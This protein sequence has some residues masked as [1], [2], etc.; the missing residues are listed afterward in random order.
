MLMQS[1]AIVSTP[2]ITKY[3]RRSSPIVD[4]APSFLYAVP[5]CIYQTVYIAATI[6]GTVE[7]YFFNSITE[8]ILPY[9]QNKNNSANV[10]LHLRCFVKYQTVCVL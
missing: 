2:Q 6:Q 5:K 9:F 4:S 7:M 1:A 10:F 8:K 3:P